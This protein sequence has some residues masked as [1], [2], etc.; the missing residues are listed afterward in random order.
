MYVA[1]SGNPFV[2][3][4]LVVIIL[5]MVS[6][7]YTH[8]SSIPMSS[9]PHHANDINTS[10]SSVVIN[11][12]TRCGSGLSLEDGSHHHSPLL[13]NVPIQN[14]SHSNGNDNVAME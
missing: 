9:S 7:L 11:N 4:V 12:G 6:R 3:V 14:I 10:I 2:L 13:M 8:A 1:I 5:L